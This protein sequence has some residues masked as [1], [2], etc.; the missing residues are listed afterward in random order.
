MSFRLMPNSDHT[1]VK[2]RRRRVWVATWLLRMYW[3]Y[4]RN[5]I[6]SPVI[7]VNS[8]NVPR[9]GAVII[10]GNHPTTREP[11]MVFTALNRNMAFLAKDS[12]F[13]HPILGP[14]LHWFGHIPVA[15][16]TDKAIE[17]T[18]FS[19]EV[20]A[21]GG[22]VVIYPEGGCTPEGEKLGEF[23]PGLAYLAQHSRAV[24]VP[25]LITGTD[26]QLPTGWRR[27]FTAKPPVTVEFGEPLPP[28][29]FSD[30]PNAASAERT[31]FTYLARTV[32]LGMMPA[33]EE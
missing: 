29:P 7:I 9:R 32:L 30:E 5:P 3:R 23:K 16:G 27:W 17:S 26:Q 31:A 10:F 14:I 1:T 20:L 24:A 4:A 8:H 22:V 6:M 13:H 11:R 18:Q 15:R 33:T 19:L 2:S 12:L 25:T 28:P 21:E